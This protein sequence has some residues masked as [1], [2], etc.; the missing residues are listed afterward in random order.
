MNEDNRTTNI[1]ADITKVAAKE[2]IKKKQIP[3]IILCLSTLIPLVFILII[4]VLIFTNII[5]FDGSANESSN[6]IATKECGFTIS[7]TSLTKEE[8]KNKLEEYAKNINSNFEVF[9]TNA[10]EIYDYAKSKRVNPEL[11]PVR[12]YVEGR[13]TTTGTNN[14]WGMGCTNT[15]GI[16]ACY[17]YDSFE[18]GYTDFINNISRYSSLADMMSKYAY[19]GEYWYN[20]GNSSIGGC[21]YAEY[22]YT[23]DNMPTRVKN[24]CSSGAP[25]CSIDNTKAC[26][27]TTEEDQTAYANW[28][29]EK[30]MANARLIIFDLDFD[31]GICSYSSGTI[32]H[33]STYNLWANG[34]NRLERTLTSNEISQLNEYINTEIDK[35]GY[36][37]AEAVVAAGQSLIYW[38]EQIGYYLP[39]YLGGGRS[40]CGD[41]NDTFIGVNP[42]WGS[43]KFGYDYGYSYGKRRIY[44]GMDCS[45]F[46][47]WAIRTACNKDFGAMGAS[48]MRFG[49]KID[50]INVQPGDLLVATDGGHVKLVVKN[51]GD[52][53]VI[54]A[55]S[56]GGST[57]ALVFSKQS[58][59]CGSKKN[60]CYDAY[61]MNTYYKNNCNATRTN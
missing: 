8:Y 46:V 28:Q 41:N 56:A 50:F 2:A 42:N 45:S 40:C 39:Y 24:A 19:I 44:L 26:I 25:M 53:T 31:D 12:A 38:L 17:N 15:G 3:I 23:E 35:A 21:Y 43:D 49:E 54:T 5:P 29:V 4:T 59:A 30:S 27:K 48:S 55:E 57:N 47:S 52:G 11:V 37:T 20:P 51:N 16:A 33:L 18:E 6:N 58:S 14:Y 1:V 13:G 61:S 32:Q 7:A 60:D 34:L 22:I 36:G 9:F 10:D